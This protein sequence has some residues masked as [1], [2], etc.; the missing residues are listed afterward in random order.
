MNAL[1]TRGGSNALE[2]QNMAEAMRF[3]ELMAD[4]TMVPKDYQGK[5]GNVLVA[6]QWGK[7]LGLAPMQALQNIS[8]IGNR[9]SV[10]GDAVLALI[11]RNPAFVSHREGIE[12]T[13]DERFGW[14]EFVRAGE[15]PFRAEFSVADAKKAGLWNKS[16][17]WQQYPDRMLRMR[18][19]G[20]A[21]RDAFADSLR[22]LVTTEE[23]MD[24]PRE[25]RD[26]PNL[27][28]P[29]PV[30]ARA[31]SM[32]EHAAEV[33]GRPVMDAGPPEDNAEALPLLY[34]DGRLI[35]IRRGEKTGAAPVVIWQRAAQQQI[36]KAE[37]PE[38]LRL[39]R[40]DM[41][42]H[43]GSIAGLHPEA[44]A[45]IERAVDAR[46]AQF[47]AEAAD[48]EQQAEAPAEAQG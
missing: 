9:P 21:S 28:E 7:E 43:L 42:P 4:S 36:A 35:E 24:A 11:R 48:A 20:F 31:G 3:A 32:A 46:Q 44:V 14:C 45:A 6:V 17:P 26:V 40:Q 19:R 33:M 22:G 41:G 10:W 23:A 29:S 1:T 8:V 38:A 5:P 47:V 18:A 13:G 12:G 34:L 39:W 16:G 27:A 25:T 37:S 30:Y 15:A 2:P